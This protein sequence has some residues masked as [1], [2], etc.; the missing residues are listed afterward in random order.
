MKV[1]IALHT[2]HD[3]ERGE[4]VR[5]LYEYDVPSDTPMGSRKTEAILKYLQLI[6]YYVEKSPN[7]SD[8]YGA[9]IYDFGKREGDTITYVGSVGELQDRWG[10]L[11]A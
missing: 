9:Y 2:I 10:V 6:G 5:R 11:S 8:E 3:V 7:S 4:P 1:V